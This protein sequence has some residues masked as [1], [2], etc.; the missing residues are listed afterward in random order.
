MP[1]GRPKG[2]TNKKKE[3]DPAYTEFNKEFAE[4]GYATTPN[5]GILAVNG[6]KF[7]TF[8][9]NWFSLSKLDKLAWLTEHRK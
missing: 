7:E 6:D 5:K 1:R 2:S 9:D 3:P 4:K 8:P